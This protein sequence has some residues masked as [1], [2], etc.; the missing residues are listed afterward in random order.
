MTSPER[1]R[2]DKAVLAAQQ[3]RV[4]VSRLRRRLREFAP[5]EDLSP[6]EVAVLTELGK[7]GPATASQLAAR[8]G[9]T[10]QSMGA[11]VSVLEQ[12]GYLH[13]SS[14]PHDGRRLLLALTDAGRERYAGNRKAREEWLVEVLERLDD[15]EL[16]TIVTAL[17]LLDRI[18]RR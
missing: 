6:S 13:R 5:G 9:I 3:L 16:D 11:K 2:T 10:G 8:E 4:V 15:A 7:H 14:D 17:D 18:G 12:R 1:Q